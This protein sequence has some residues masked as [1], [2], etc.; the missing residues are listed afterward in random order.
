MARAFQDINL[1]S[2]C[3]HYFAFLNGILIFKLHVESFSCGGL[4]VFCSN[5][6]HL[7]TLLQSTAPALISQTRTGKQ[8]VRTVLGVRYA[9]MVVVDGAG[10]SKDL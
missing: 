9:R 2:V 10:R 1:I 5:Q 8:L 7:F 6:A 3:W 4:R